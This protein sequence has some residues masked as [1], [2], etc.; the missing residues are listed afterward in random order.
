MVHKP[1]REEAH[2][3]QLRLETRPLLL[4]NS[5]FPSGS[6]GGG[7][8][9]RWLLGPDGDKKVGK[10]GVTKDP[11]QEHWSFQP[12]EAVSPRGQSWVLPPQKRPCLGIRRVGSCASF[13]TLWLGVWPQLSGHSF[14]TYKTRGPAIHSCFYRVSGEG[15]PGLSP[16]RDQ[17]LE[18]TPG[19]AST[20]PPSGAS[21]S[22]PGQELWAQR[23]GWEF[24]VPS[25][26]SEG[27]EGRCSPM[28]PFSSENK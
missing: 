3:S 28:L 16:I 12:Q 9:F 23:G 18:E 26:D 20:E 8:S 4:P 24:L 19:Q 1:R 25:S 15:P 7:C 27:E 21:W 17:R 22:E 11:K 6:N 14:F 2:S 10:G 5:P 13:A